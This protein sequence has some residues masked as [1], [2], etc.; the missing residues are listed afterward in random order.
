MTAD[1]LWLFC[2]CSAGSLGS[3]L[4]GWCGQDLEWPRYWP[5]VKGILRSPVGLAISSPSF[6]NTPLL[7][8]VRPSHPIP[9]S[10]PGRGCPGLAPQGSDRDQSGFRATC[11]LG[12]GPL[13]HP[14]VL[15]LASTRPFP[16]GIKVGWGW[17]VAGGQASL[18][19]VALG[20]LPSASNSP[21]INSAYSS[22]A[23][24][25]PPVLGGSR[26][27]SSSRAA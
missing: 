5:D 11:L 9:D 4:P 25:Q 8:K 27:G 15:V 16:C 12:S 3:E 21:T 17:G 7:I 26:M 24:K 1:S 22:R 19:A 14:G 20:G 2:L 10:L 23:E 13:S 18:P 6:P